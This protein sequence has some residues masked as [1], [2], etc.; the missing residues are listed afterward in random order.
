MRP[1]SS[2]KLQLEVLEDRWLLSIGTNLTLSDSV[3]GTSTYG[4]NVL[5]TATLVTTNNGPVTEGMVTF[6]EG[7]STLASVSVSSNGS[8]GLA[9]YAT[10]ALSANTHTI[11]ASY[12]DSLA[13]YGPSSNTDRLAVNP[14]PLTITAANQTMIF[15]GTFPSLTVGH[16][17]GFVNG[18]TASSLT[19]PPT[20]S[21]TATVNSGAGSYPIH[22]SGAVDSNYTISYVNGTFT[23]T[24]DTAT[25][26]LLTS[27]PTVP[28][29]QQAMLSATVAPG[30]SSSDTETGSVVFSDGNTPL[31][32]IPV[33]AFGRVAVA[34][35]NTPNLTTG[36][37]TLTASYSGDA[38]HTGSTSS[39][40]TVTV[41]AP[42]PG[43]ISGTVFRDD[44]ANG[45]QD[46]GEPGIQGQTLFLDL[47]GSGQ[48]K[49]ADPTA[50]TDPNGNYQFTVTAGT[51][52][53]RQ[54]LLGGVLLR[55]PATADYQV[56]V[57]IGATVSGQNFAEIPTSISVPLT[58]PP[59]TSFVKQ[60]S[61]NA[62]YVEG[63]YRAIL[64]RD[65]DASGLAGWT[66][67]LNSGALSRLQVVQGIRNSPEHFTDEI[68]DFYNTLLG[69]APDS[70]GLQNWVRQLQAGMKEE[71]I[72]FYFLDSP[73]YLSQGDK[74]FVDAMYLSLLGRAF[75]AAGEVGW[76][77][78]LGDD[79]T[80]N[81][82]HSAT[83]THEQ[84]IS[85]F[86]YSSESEIR[87]TQGYYEVFLQRPADNAG[88]NGW[89]VQLQQGTRFLT[90]GQQFLSSDE[91]YNRAAGQ[92]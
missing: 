63:L 7:G 3:S 68:T 42:P 84:V 92:G 76:L 87:L 48:L 73:E 58:L 50:T 1:R 27:T 61:A 12:T 8:A 83:L 20:L 70:A 78:Q 16:Y 86:L 11:T 28:Y 21:T 56:T 30:L 74:H 57:G 80:G 29:G 47:D 26:S 72:A 77:S 33:T 40:V 14:A 65:A 71:Q 15:G 69:R 18:D 35:F 85:D 38:N 54:L 37:H 19:A 43:V 9:T 62:D 90:I 39:A 24:P 34:G 4:Q 59:N 10:A 81:P 41:G 88:L 17:T 79:T 51:Y 91:F 2:R 64:D 25:T 45:A 6:S 49:P 44:N 32:T 66:A 75:D 67:Q 82:T 89:V 52:T 13:T 36:V 53:V 55:A 22:P 5:F 23:I 60:G 31:A 46:S